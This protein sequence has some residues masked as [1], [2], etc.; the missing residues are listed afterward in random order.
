LY[1]ADREAFA[2][3]VGT[4]ILYNS[5]LIFGAVPRKV[6]DEY[7]V[8][9]GRWFP[10]P[11]RIFDGL[12][13]LHYMK[14]EPHHLRRALDTVRERFGVRCGPLGHAGSR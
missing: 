9:L 3:T 11:R 14:R 8:D 1:R 2:V 12:R 13:F 7:G 4:H 10:A 6:L 5:S